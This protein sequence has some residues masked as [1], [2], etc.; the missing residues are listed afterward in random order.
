MRAISVAALV[1]SLAFVGLRADT[2]PVANDYYGHMHM[3]FEK[4]WL[5][6]DVARI[7]V[8]FDAAAAEH[9]RELA[10]GQHYSDQLAEQIARTALDAQD[11]HVQ[12]EFLRDVSIGEFIDAARDNLKRARDA[13]YIS[14]D[15]YAVALQGA[16]NDFAPLAKRGLKEHDVLVYRARPDSLQTTVMSGNRVLLDV[17]SLNLGSR[18]AM[19]ASYFAPK[20]DFRKGLIKS[21]F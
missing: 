12:V 9:F 4:T 17:T 1:T 2:A 18:R 6:F 7:D 13:N 10:A 15:V 19:I 14:K 21:L 16:K 11:V 20:S 3:L 8:R 5:G